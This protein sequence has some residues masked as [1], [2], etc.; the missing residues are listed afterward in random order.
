MVPEF[1]KVSVY[2]GNLK[3]WIPFFLRP[4][5]LNMSPYLFLMPI[6]FVI[7]YFIVKTLIIRFDV[8]T[9]G[10]ELDESTVRLYNK[11][12][13]AKEKEQAGKGSTKADRKNAKKDAASDL[14]NG[15]ISGLGGAANIE[16]VDNCISRLRVIVKD[17]SLIASD[18]IW[19]NDLEA[20][21]VVRLNKEFQIIYGARVAGVAVDVRDALGSD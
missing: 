16:E 3:D 10:R 14:A 4:E 18:E 2:Q 12:D 5:K 20:L 13:L 21:G 6:F 8:K 11:A 19:K 15:I 7:T 1:F 9:P 17:P